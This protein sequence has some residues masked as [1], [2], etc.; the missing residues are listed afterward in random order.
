MF[1]RV[2]GGK[3]TSYDDTLSGFQDWDIWLTLANRKAVQLP[4]DL[5]L[6]YV[7]GG[8]GSFRQQRAN[9][10][11][12]LDCLAASDSYPNKAGA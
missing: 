11:S 10:M 3:V 4:R 8:G 12:G 7:V 1:R 2:I 5:Y 9:A 6:L